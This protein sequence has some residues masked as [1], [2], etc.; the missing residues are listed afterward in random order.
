[1]RGKPKTQ[2]TLTIA[3]KGE[4]QPIVIT[5]TREVIKVQSV[6]S[7]VVEPGY[8]YVRIDAV[9][10]EHR[11]EPGRAP[12]QARRYKQGPVKGLVLDLRNDPGGLLHGAVGVSA[13]FLPRRRWW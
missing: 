4:S 8:A 10:G 1:M 12:R 5:L 11:R 7:K 3:R 13:A 6:K 2:I 9:P